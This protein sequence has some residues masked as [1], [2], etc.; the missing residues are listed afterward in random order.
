LRVKSLTVAFNLV[1]LRIGTSQLS[2]KTLEE[3]RIR[4]TKRLHP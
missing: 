4:S 3:I 2:E 1:P